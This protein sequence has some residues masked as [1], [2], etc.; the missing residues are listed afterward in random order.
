MVIVENYNIE[1]K[2]ELA[3]EYKIKIM[4]PASSQ[5]I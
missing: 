3:K 4:Q 5:H 1:T 2:A